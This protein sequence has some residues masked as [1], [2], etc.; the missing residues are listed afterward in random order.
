MKGGDV[1]HDMYVIRGKWP[2]L[3][4]RCLWRARGLSLNCDIPHI[5]FK[6]IF[7]QIRRT[8]LA[9]KASQLRHA[10]LFMVIKR[11]LSPT[12]YVSNCNLTNGIQSG[13]ELISWVWCM[14]RQIM[15]V[16][17]KWFVSSWPQ[18]VAVNDVW[19]GVSNS[20]RTQNVTAQ[21]WHL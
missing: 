11:A 21:T 4:G 20:T 7:T 9:V 16:C 10:I 3:C 14:C 19:F 6:L 15:H 5:F 8:A 18:R 1:E 12:P 17:A 2:G 13:R